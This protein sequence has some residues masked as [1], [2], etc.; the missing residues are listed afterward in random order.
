MLYAAV[1]RS[2]HPHAKI[3]SI[4]TEKAEALKGVK[5]VITGDEFTKRGGLYLEDKNFLAVGKARYQGE[6]VVALCAESEDIAQAALELIDVE[7]EV[8]P[9]VT[10]AVEGMKPESPPLVHPRPE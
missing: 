4:N 5:C 2:P 1:K 10:N 3:I 6:A 9:A 7:Y 8:L